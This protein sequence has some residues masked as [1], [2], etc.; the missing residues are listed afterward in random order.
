MQSPRSNSQPISQP[1]PLEAVLVLG[2]VLCLT[3][4]KCEYSSIDPF[5]C[6]PTIANCAASERCLYSTATA[7]TGLVRQ[8]LKEK[9]CV[10]ASECGVHIEKKIAGLI[11]RYTT[12]CCNTDLCNAAAP[13]SSH[14]WPRIALILGGP[15]LAVLLTS[16]GPF[17][18]I[19]TCLPHLPLL[20][21]PHKPPFGPSSSPPAWQL[22]L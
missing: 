11:F 6:I 16:L 22:H 21:Q 5:K 12:R 14:F 8:E 1:K 7:S 4:Y 20:L 2:Q 18:S 13:S 15:V 3:C 19:Q 9:K 10:P 17:V